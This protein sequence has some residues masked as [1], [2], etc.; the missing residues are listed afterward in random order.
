MY[1]ARLKKIDRLSGTGTLETTD[2]K[3]LSVRYELHVFRE[4]VQAGPGEEL[5]GFLD[6]KGH[7]KPILP[8]SYLDPGSEFTLTLN[9]GG[10]IQIIVA[11][12]G[13]GT[14]DIKIKDARD[15]G[16]RYEGL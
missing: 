5:P 1:H 3:T 13:S 15:F 11:N 8:G 16:R 14:S 12:G 6:I 4:M 2:K 10:K 9:D 7:V